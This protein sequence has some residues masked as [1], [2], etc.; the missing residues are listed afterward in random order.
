MTKLF[1]FQLFLAAVAG[2]A[3]APTSITPAMPIS[4]PEALDMPSSYVLGAGDQISVSMWGSPDFD[5]AY[6]IA[7]D[8]TFS[9]KLLGE[10]KAEGLTRQQLEDAI[11]K[12]ASRQ[13]RT[14]R[15]TVNL[16]ASHSKRIYFDGEGIGA[17]TMDLV[18]PLHLSEALSAHSCCKDFAHKDKIQV[19][20]GGEPLV[21]EEDGKPVKYFKYKEAMFSAGHPERNPVLQDGDHIWVP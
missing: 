20:R 7:P 14:P 17:G 1:A 21:H 2:W 10:I 6:T 16:L 8:G 13:L 4:T 15:A 12:A 9:M 5:G 11:N 18:K 3:Q 19:I